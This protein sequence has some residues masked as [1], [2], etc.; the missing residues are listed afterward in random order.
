MV[1]VDLFI[2]P[3]AVADLRIHYR[4]RQQVRRMDGNRIQH[5]M[6]ASE[7]LFRQIATIGT[8]ISD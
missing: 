4:L 6:A 2:I 7:V 8:R 1:R 5:R 3:A